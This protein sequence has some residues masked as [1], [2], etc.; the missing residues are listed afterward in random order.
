MSEGAAHFDRRRSFLRSVS[1]LASGT[2][3]AQL[4]AL[5]AAPLLTRIYDPG[6]FGVLAAYTSLL[7]L[8]IVVASG[9][10]P[11]AVV[12][13]D[14]DREAEDLVRGSIR[15]GL[16]VALASAWPIRLGA[17]TLARALEAP[18]LLDTWWILPLGLAAMVPTP[19]LVAWATRTGRVRDAAS[20]K[21]SDGLGRVGGQIGLG[22]AGL[23]TTG[24]LLG[25]V[26]GRALASLRLGWRFWREAGPG[27]GEVLATFR[28][29]WRFPVITMPGGLVNAAA[30]QLP[31]LLL[32]AAFGVEVAGQ[33]A[34]GHRVVLLPLMLVG[35]AVAQ[36]YAVEVGRARSRGD[37]GLAR[38][39]LRL[40][41]GLGALMLAP[42]LLGCFLAPS[43]F[44][45]LFGPEW[46]P[47]G[48]LVQLLAP[49]YLLQAAVFPVAQTLTLLEVQRWQLAWD[50]GR[51]GA[52]VLALTLPPALGGGVHATVLTYGLVMAGSYAVLWWLGR[53]ALRHSA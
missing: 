41:I 13:P 45:V 24:L 22:L 39:H 8:G 4:V 25:D 21:L 19:P 15:L 26:I 34:L 17:A 44:V 2:A 10:Y 27:C 30:L 3:M 48:E 33:F 28:R 38:R 53:L 43:G 7:G 11:L 50:V 49:L 18:G 16:L 23:G 20:S 47:A 46:R 52:V 29:Y 6:A 31:P 36:M 5:L 42:I 40:S 51:L 14:E 1:V 12:L 35:Q 9:R 32:T 37:G